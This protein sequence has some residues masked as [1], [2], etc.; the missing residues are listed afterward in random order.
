MRR[1]R[2]NPP[3]R[4]SR[5]FRVAGSSAEAGSSY[6]VTG[7]SG[8]V[9]LHLI[10]RLLA[11]GHRVRGTLR[12]REREPA[13]RQALAQRDPGGERLEFVEAT[14]ESDAGWDAATAGVEGVFH[15]A[16]PVPGRVPLVDASFVGPARDGTL[17]VLEAAR[18]AGVRRVVLTSSVAA[19]T[20]GHA[21]RSAPFTEADWSLAD[22][23]QPYEKSKTVAERA[24]WEFSAA[25]PAG[26]E[27]ATVNP[28][29]VLGPL[30]VAE[31]SP[32]LDIVRNLVERRQPGVADLHFGIV[33]VRDVAEA[34]W[35]A[36]IRPEAKGQRFLCNTEVLS[37]AEIAGLL[38]AQL[39][40]R[41]LRIPTRRLPSWFVRAVGL[42]D[43]TVRFVVPRLGK[44]KELDSSKLRSTLG[45]EPRPV[46][47]TLRDTAESLLAWAG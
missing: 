2:L 27:L 43:P 5:P 26:P 29:F 11:R 34:H 4:S 9:A 12:R 25:H 46:A 13:L 14:L 7:A 39:G 20:S 31:R 40:P 36:M 28:S 21:V 17:R 41:G 22:R 16:S 47:E 1:G 30:L 23:A 44:R 19:I 35:L 42:F 6:L 3:E 24:A 32:S 45:W 38:A 10:D 37:H 8:F 18:R 15:V 33:D